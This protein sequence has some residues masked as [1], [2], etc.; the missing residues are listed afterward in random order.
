MLTIASFLTSWDLHQNLLTA[1]IYYQFKPPLPPTATG[2]QSW[3]ILQIYSVWH[4][5]ISLALS[6]SPW[7]QATTHTHYRPCFPLLTLICV[8]RISWLVLALSS[9]HSLTLHSAASFILFCPVTPYPAHVSVQYSPRPPPL[10][11]PPHIQSW[12]L[13]NTEHQVCLVVTVSFFK[14]WALLSI[15]NW[16][17]CLEQACSLQSK[18]T[19]VIVLPFL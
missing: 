2:L 8:P 10:K 17:R 4:D 5:L 11:T 7:T 6:H 13:P 1:T 16:F 15:A 12:L 18:M 19:F 14:L 9:L 3:Y